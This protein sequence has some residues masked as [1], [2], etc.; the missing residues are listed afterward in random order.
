MNDCVSK[1]FI[2]PRLAVP[3]QQITNQMKAYAFLYGTRDDI[4]IL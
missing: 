3:F 1:L 4:I 2:S